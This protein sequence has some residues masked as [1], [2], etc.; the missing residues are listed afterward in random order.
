M[1]LLP[2]E[3]E[4]YAERHSHALTPSVKSVLNELERIT[5]LRVLLPQMVSGSLQGEWLAFLSY[6]IRPRRVLEIGTF[7][8]YSSICLAQG[9]PQDGHLHTIDINEELLPIIREYHQKAGLQ[10][11]I[12][13]HIGDA[14]QI[15]DQLEGNFDL[16]FIDADKA[17]YLAYYHQVIDRVPSG[18]FILADNVL[19]SGKVWMPKADKTTQLLQEFNETID[20]DPRVRNFLI[21]IR[22]GLMLLQKV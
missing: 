22:D 9:M 10:D 5:H 11:R 8:G 20:N 4:Q 14:R 12:T 3:M 1:N 7:T 18:G 21:P 13:V 17:N 19:W 16:V 6:M 2:I 15:I